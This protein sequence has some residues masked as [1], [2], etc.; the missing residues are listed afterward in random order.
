MTD[1]NET[2]EDINLEEALASGF[3]F[4]ELLTLAPQQPNYGFSL[5]H[6]RVFVTWFDAKPTTDQEYLFVSEPMSIELNEEE[7]KD[8]HDLLNAQMDQLQG[9]LEGFV[10]NREGVPDCNDP[11]QPVNA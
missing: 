7:A 2:V 6:D 3:E 4:D 11:D 1:N 5:V 9:L 8:F 10:K